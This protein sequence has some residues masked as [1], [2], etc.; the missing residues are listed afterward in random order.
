MPAQRNETLRQGPVHRGSIGIGKVVLEQW[1]GAHAPTRHG[2]TAQPL[3]D[4]PI[5]LLVYHDWCSW[6]AV[7][8]TKLVSGFETKIQC[9]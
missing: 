9:T 3:V 8:F 7:F 6:P 4:Q 5:E 2:Q 1:P